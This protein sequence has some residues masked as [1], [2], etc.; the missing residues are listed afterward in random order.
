[1]SLRVVISHYDRRPLEPLAALLDSLERHPAG[2][3][4]AATIVVNSTGDRV[5]PETI[6]ARVDNV[7]VRPNVGMNI[8]AWDAGWR[9]DPE[10]SAFLFLQDECYAVADAWG[11]RYL[12]ALEDP[13]A[14]LVGESLNAAW[15]RPWEVLRESVGRTTMPE[16]LV[17]GRPA[18]RVDVY[19]DVL[20][21]HGIEPGLTARH[22]RSLVWALRG[23][24]LRAIGGFPIGTNY[25]ECIG[26][27][28]AV[29]RA[30]EALRLELR[31]VCALPFAVF[32]H[33]EWNQDVPGGAWTHRAVQLEELARLKRENAEL[34]A[35]LEEIGR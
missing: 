5:L 4:Y 12:A 14:G 20:R 27:E 16:H 7:V 31:C 24:V 13:G 2:V 21:R 11:A 19:R 1:M 30:V 25:G 35:R 8:G 15:D 10:A 34:R 9:T 26:A 28:I 32:R 23:D 17:D 22:V 29:S 33:L 18:N 6:A 3:P